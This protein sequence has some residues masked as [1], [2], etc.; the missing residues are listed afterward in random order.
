[1]HCR[2]NCHSPTSQSQQMAD[3]ASRGLVVGRSYDF[4]SMIIGDGSTTISIFDASSD[5]DLNSQLSRIWPISYVLSSSAM[6]SW[7]SLSKC[8]VSRLFMVLIWWLPGVNLSW[9][10]VYFASFAKK[11]HHFCLEQLQPSYINKEEHEDHGHRPWRRALGKNPCYQETY[12]ASNI[13]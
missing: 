11:Y 1:M 6:L 4:M 9:L 2:C 7:L 3:S 13:F 10:L 12:E 8:S 5:C